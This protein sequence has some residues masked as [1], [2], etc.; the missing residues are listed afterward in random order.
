MNKKLTAATLSIAMAVTMAPTVMQTASVNAA[1]AA[2]QSLAGGAIAMAYVS[3]ALNKMDNSEQGQ[4]ESLARTKEKT[5]YLNDSAA[6]ARVQRILKTLGFLGSSYCGSVAT[7]PISIHEDERLILG[8]AQWVK[9][10]A[11][12]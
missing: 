1:S 4:Q 9:D 12:A 8:F 6:Q 5:G 7:N 2:V 11:L 3:T 10:L